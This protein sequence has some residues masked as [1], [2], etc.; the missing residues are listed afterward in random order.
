[1]GGRRQGNKNKGYSYKENTK[2]NSVNI[3]DKL[4]TGRLFIKT[5]KNKL[6]DERP[7]E[8]SGGNH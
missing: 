4:G 1:M 6:G 8:S 5:A 2:T 7:N 3:A